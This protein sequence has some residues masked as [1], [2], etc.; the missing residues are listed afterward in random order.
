[1][2]TKKKIKGSMRQE[3]NFRT[4]I[5]MWGLIQ[6][7][8]PNPDVVLRKRGAG[9]SIYRELLSDSHLTAALESRQA[10]TMANDW[11]LQQDDCPA[12]LYKAI[13]RWFFSV[14]ER[15]SNVNDL[16]K[17]ETI[18]NLL[19]VIYFGY[20][21]TEL[22]W[23]YQYG[24]WVPVKIIPKP[25]EWFTW[26]IKDDG[27]PE[28][29]FMS[30]AHPI[31]GE[32]PPDEWT[33]VCPRVRPSYANPYGRGVASRCFWPLIFKKAGIEFWMNFM[34]RFGTPW[35]KGTMETVSDTDTV[36]TFAADLKDLVQD[37]VIA[38]SKG[39]NVELLETSGGTG[40][41]SEGFKSLCDYFDGQMSK[42]ILGH[43][44]SMDVGD[45]GSYAASRGAQSVR[46]DYGEADSLLIAATFNDIINLI[47]L[48]NGF[49][50]TP[51]PKLIPFRRKVV[52]TERAQRD[53]ALSRAGVVFKKAYYQ[54]AYALKPDEFEVTDPNKVQA[55]G[56]KQ[57]T[58][59]NVPTNTPGGVKGGENNVA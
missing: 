25:P 38:V 9:V 45:K 17:S 52:E 50:G 5:E 4:S 14:I 13:E 54:R 59:S 6:R 8:L 34:E 43:G 7:R 56:L 30:L 53:E 12:R 22:V 29:R 55:T 35:V 32:P 18:E 1:M 11:E 33:L 48:R 57:V 58:D 15:K 37:A 42:T 31:D 40:K 36:E 3:F 24:L 16:N 51:R 39:K 44:L 19:D 46:G 10:V 2:P 27:N 23:G 20:Q 49:D 28:L 21:P 26:F 41:I 47:H